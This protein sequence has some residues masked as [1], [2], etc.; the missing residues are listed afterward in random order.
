LKDEIKIT[1]VRLNNVIGE[2]EINIR[3]GKTILIF[4][5]N[6]EVEWKAERGSDS[7]GGSYK[8]NEIAGDDLDDIMVQF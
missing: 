6:L 5:F 2:A 7:A 3:K 8:V 1:T 4:E